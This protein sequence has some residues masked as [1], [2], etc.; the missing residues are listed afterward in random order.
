MKE[1]GGSTLGSLVLPV[2]LP[3]F[4]LAAGDGA[5]NTFLPLYF[6]HLGTSV[7]GAALLVGIGTAGILLF[8][9]PSGFIVARYG[10]RRVLAVSGAGIV[11]AA[12]LI[13]VSPTPAVATVGVFLVSGAASFWL[14]GR[15]EFM[16]KALTTSARGRGL[17]TVGGVMRAG[18]L[19]G[20]LVGG[21]VARAAGYRVV[22][23]GTAV[24]GVVSLLLFLLSPA[25]RMVADPPRG[26]AP[27]IWNA[28]ALRR[29]I[30]ARVKVLTTAGLSMLVLSMV[31]S[32][33]TLLLPLWGQVIGLDA[34][35]IGLV[36]GISAAGDTLMF[37]PAGLVSDRKGRKW[38][39]VSC[40]VALSL[41]MAMIPLTHTLGSFVLVGLLVGLGNGMGSGINMTLGADFAA[42]SEP[43]VFLGLW[44]LVTDI[45]GAA[46]PFVIGVVTSALALGPAALVIAALGLAGGG[47]HAAAVPETLRKGSG[48]EV[49]ALRKESATTRDKDEARG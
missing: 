32:G 1:P 10:E 7:A 27:P 19:L 4:L 30:R 25:T 16:R 12:L 42:D 37:Y 41:G 38:S 13:A 35:G 48:A 8:D 5:M 49:P 43:G 9:L 39:A 26:K 6:I 2:Y 11:A 31:R 36:V 18:L 14:L 15:L 28:R 29:V 34:A 24:L 46:A 47:F 45:G 40:L 21:L 3:A 44:R 17:A 20:P 23:L 22:F 33:R